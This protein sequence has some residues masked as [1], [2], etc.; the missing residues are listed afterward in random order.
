MDDNIRNVSLISFM[1]PPVQES[2]S[3]N[4][5]TSSKVESV[6]GKFENKTA[7]LIKSQYLFTNKL[8]DH[9]VALSN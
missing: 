8:F 3:I 9:Y 6:V 4:L 5:C 2:F 7:H 1:S